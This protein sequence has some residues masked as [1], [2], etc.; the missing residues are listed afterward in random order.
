[1]FIPDF[2][3]AQPSILLRSPI[4]GTALA[5]LMVLHI[6]PSYYA[7]IIATGALG[8]VGTAAVEGG[9]RTGHRSSPS[10]RLYL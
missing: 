4:D 6:Q 2:N 7:A 3:K 8:Q 9:R 5:T 1:M 10:C